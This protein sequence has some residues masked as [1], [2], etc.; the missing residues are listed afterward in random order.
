MRTKI[1]WTDWSLNPIKGK[2]KIGCPYC[3]AIRMYNRFK[4]NPDVKLDLNVFNRLP[5]KPSKIFLC[6][7]HEMFGDWIPDEWIRAILSKVAEFPQH[8]FLILTKYPLRCSKFTFPNNVWLGVTVENQLKTDRIAV[9]KCLNVKTK[10]V[11]FE[12][13]HSSIEYNLSNI[14]WVII[15]SETGN[16]AGKIV[17][18]K[19]WIE[20]LIFL[21]RGWECKIFMKNNLKPYWDGELIQEFP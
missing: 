8:T 2:C 6:S 14:D 4:W 12:P 10:F 18:K 1:E 13:L 9:L 15:G 16:R 3:Y 7:T 21:S 19:E 17:P 5:K 11:S 20:N